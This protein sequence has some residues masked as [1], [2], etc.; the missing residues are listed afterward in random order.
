MNAPIHGIIWKLYIDYIDIYLEN[1]K[2]KLGIK[3]CLNDYHFQN[4]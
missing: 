3:N 2:K 1:I 4:Q